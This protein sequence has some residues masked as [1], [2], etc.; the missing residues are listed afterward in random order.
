[1]PDFI[2]STGGKPWIENFRNEEKARKAVNYRGYKLT[3]IELATAEAKEQFERERADRVESPKPE[4]PGRQAGTGGGCGVTEENLGELWNLTKLGKPLRRLSLVLAF[5]FAIAAIHLFYL[6][7]TIEAL[8]AREVLRVIALFESWAPP[9]FC[10]SILIYFLIRGVNYVGNL[11]I[12]IGI[13][14]YFPLSLYAIFLV[15]FAALFLQSYM[16][17]LI[18]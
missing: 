6:H 11:G 18:F 8:H 13:V 17:T 9:F 10:V 14:V 12:Y 15:F 5:I 4:G 3:S 7:T 16:E 1:M 2:L